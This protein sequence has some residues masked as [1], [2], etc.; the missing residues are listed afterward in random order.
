MSDDEPPATLERFWDDLRYAVG[1]IL[2]LFGAPEAIAARRMLVRRTR[3]DILAWLAPIEA[4]ARRILL[5]AALEA[6]ACNAAAPTPS[7]RVPV[8]SAMRDTPFRELSDNPADWRVLFSDWP[9]DANCGAGAPARK[10]TAGE[11]AGASKDRRFADYTAY[12]LARRLE[13]L[14]RLARDPG[15]AITRMARKIAQRRAHLARAFA[16]Y[17][18]RSL[19]VQTIL[20][21]VQAQ[22]DAALV[23][24]S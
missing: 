5:L 11:G 16:P 13:A 7:Y 14:I 24:T 8:L 17:R 2:A 6:P 4:M 9:G 22:V 23:N 1:M 18:H 10:R 19:P 20:A 12:P 21:R 15:A 3:Q